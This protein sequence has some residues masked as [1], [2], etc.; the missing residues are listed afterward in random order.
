MASSLDAV[1]LQLGIFLEGG[2]YTPLWTAVMDATEAVDAD[3]DISDDDREWFDELYDAVYMGAEDPLDA[4]SAKDG[5]VGAADLRAQIRE[6]RLDR[7]D[8]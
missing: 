3:P 7:S 5:M 1:R 8:G 2:D 6:M 4:Q